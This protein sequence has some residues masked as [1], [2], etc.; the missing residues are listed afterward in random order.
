MV[1]RGFVDRTGE[2]LDTPT[3]EFY[4]PDISPGLF[5]RATNPNQ[6]EAQRRASRN[7]TRLRRQRERIAEQE[8]EREKIAF[9]KRMLN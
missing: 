6:T 5:L 8:C 7:A 4:E 3:I 1:E 2:F 9:Q